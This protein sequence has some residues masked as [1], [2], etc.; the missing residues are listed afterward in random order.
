MKTKLNLTTDIIQDAPFEELLKH[1]NYLVRV[2]V[3]QSWQGKIQIDV[4]A[5]AKPTDA[6]FR[7]TEHYVIARE[8]DKANGIAKVQ[9]GKKIIGKLA[10]GSFS[11]VSVTLAVTHLDEVKPLIQQTIDVIQAQ[12]SNNI[13]ELEAFQTELNVQA[14]SV[15]DAFDQNDVNKS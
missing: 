8:A 3:E 2:T 14:K 11:Q 13:N 4:N 10:L 5:Y 7:E 15:I 12:I 6:P 1:A 9:V